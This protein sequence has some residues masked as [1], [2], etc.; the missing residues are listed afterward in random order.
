M[1]YKPSL[2][3]KTMEQR[4]LPFRV[5]ELQGEVDEI[6]QQITFFRSL[7]T[8]EN[9]DQIGTEVEEQKREV[10][11]LKAQIQD[12]TLD[13][14]L[15]FSSN[16]WEEVKKREQYMN[17]MKETIKEHN[18]ELKQLRK[19]GRKMMSEAKILQQKKDPIEEKL[20]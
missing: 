4:E 17:I 5:C 16:E 9:R 14:E 6:D 15:I 1:K 3:Q 19:E 10:V 18:A 7:F 13:S 8:K 12:I 11:H 20:I 2:T